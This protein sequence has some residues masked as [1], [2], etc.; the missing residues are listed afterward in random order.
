MNY[1]NC[2][3]TNW[4]F[5]DGIR[6]WTISPMDNASVQLWYVGESGFINNDSASKYFAVRPVVYLSNEIIFEGNGSLKNP[7]NIK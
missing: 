4:M 2:R 3:E 5:K 1:A 6:W 7:Y